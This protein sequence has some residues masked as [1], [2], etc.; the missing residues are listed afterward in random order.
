MD[1]KEFAES[2]EGKELA[3][4]EVQE[5]QEEKETPEE[6]SSTE[7]TPESEPK[8]DDEKDKAL[9]QGKGLDGELDKLEK[10]N[11]ERRDRIVELR[12]ERREQKE[13]LGDNQR[14]VQPEQT[15]STDDNYDN[16]ANYVIGEFVK[17]H[18]EYGSENDS[19]DAKWKEL[20][21]ES[22]LAEN[23]PAN[24][25]EVKKRL[26]KAHAYIAA[27][28]PIPK[29]D[30]A[31]ENAQKESLKMAGQGAGNSGTGDSS[32]EYNDSDVKIY[33]D[34]GYPEKKAIKLAT[35]VFSKKG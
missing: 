25:F 5:E 22:E 12:S 11:A 24:P 19:G 31:K 7:K 30:P 17:E 15:E 2:E 13:E 32:K 29:A 14:N 18:P 16:S 4:A 20:Y 9:S 6:D 35:K 34:M 10:E 28:N 33:T 21:R 23:R 1:K 27:Q 26:E 3:P 8:E